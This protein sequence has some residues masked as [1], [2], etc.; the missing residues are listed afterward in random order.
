MLL[1]GAVYLARVPA[2]GRLG[3]YRPVAVRMVVVSV[4][5]G[6]APRDPAWACFSSFRRWCVFDEEGTC[7]SE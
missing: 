6:P 2:L 5:N 4:L 3:M 7:V 1:S